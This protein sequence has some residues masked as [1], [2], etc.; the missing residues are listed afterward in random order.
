MEIGEIDRLLES[1][2]PSRT[3]K[4]A[5][6]NFAPEMT[7]MVMLNPKDTIVLL[8]SGAKVNVYTDEANPELS[9][10]LSIVRDGIYEIVNGHSTTRTADLI[11]L[12][13]DMDEGLLT[14]PKNGGYNTA[15][16]IPQHPHTQSFC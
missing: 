15:L 1:H 9:V 14:P 11:D 13:M 6:P 7:I 12:D 3:F 4:V 5:V 16:G 8:Y 10:V 2:I